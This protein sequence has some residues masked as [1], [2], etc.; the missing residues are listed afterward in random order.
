MAEKQVKTR[1]I[2]KHDTE[3]NWDKATNFIPKQGELIVY[4]IDSS[5]SYERFKVGD[6]AT[7]VSN[8]PFYLESNGYMTRGSLTGTITPSILAGL[9]YGNYFVQLSSTTKF[10]SD[11]KGDVPNST[12]LNVFCNGMY[13]TGTNLIICDIFGSNIW[14]YNPLESKFYKLALASNIPSLKTIFGQSIS[15]SGSIT[16][17]EGYLNWGGQNKSGTFG[18]LDA[19]LIPTLGANRLAFMPASAI[20]IE[21]SQDGGTTWTDYEA[22]SNDKI[23]LFNDQ[24]TEFH[25]GKSSASKI[26]KSSYMLRVTI[27]TGAGRVYTD[28]RKF[29]IYISTNGSSGSYCTITG[30]LQQDVASGTETWKTFVEKASLSGWSGWN[31]INAAFTTYGNAPSWQYGQVRFT[32]G[33][34]SHPAT[35]QYNGLSLFKILGFGGVGWT[36][37]SILATKGR[38]YTWDEAQNVTFPASLYVNNISGI[39]RVATT[40]QVPGVND[41][42]LGFKY[43]EDSS[44]TTIVLDAGTSTTTI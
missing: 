2:N 5:H 23:K 39:K 12:Y 18:P 32:F 35:V 26:D 31:I 33:V 29:A 43:I 36:T 24:G 25:I 16:P 21:Y 14:T 40:D 42:T 7:T 1:I 44:D 10:S 8:L 4:D 37:P 20:T 27:S 13:T 34:S 17:Y 22:S 3:A 30:R 15:G 11:F 19:A 6:G 9:K 28:L 38:M 41:N